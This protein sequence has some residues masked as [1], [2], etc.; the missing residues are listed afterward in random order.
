M[1]R[2]AVQ[3]R[4]PQFHFGKSVEAPSHET[5]ELANYFAARDRAEFPYQTIPEQN[6]SYLAERDKAHSGYLE[7]GWLMMT[8]KASP[9]LRVSC[10]WPVQ[11][12]WRRPGCEWSR[13]AWGRLRGSAPSI[14]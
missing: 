1:I 4:M 8:N 2:P 3:L 11:A 7:A 6:V 5:E 13:P 9:C 14:C 10:D 12:Q